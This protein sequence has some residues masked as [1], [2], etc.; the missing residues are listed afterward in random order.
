MTQALRAQP[1]APGL[2]G[3]RRSGAVTELLF[4]FECL[5]RE[6]AQ[7]RP[8]AD[9]LGLTVQAASHSFRQL[10]RRGLAEHRE[11]R[12]RTTVRGVA[13]LHEV[14]GD[15][16]EDI[17]ERAARLRVIRSCR[18]IAREPLPAHA[19][20]S[21]ELDDGLLYAR[22]GAGPG[23]RG[24]TQG[25][26]RRGE[27]V[28]VSDLEG[29]VPL[30]RAP[31]RILTLSSGDLEDPDLTL[32]LRRALRAHPAGLLGAQGLEAFHALRRA[33][34]VPVVR[35]AVAAQVDEASRLGVPSTVLL[36]PSELPRFLSQMS[37]PDPPPL[38]VFALGGGAG[39][40]HRTRARARRRAQLRDERSE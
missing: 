6:P 37:E 17:R 10:A 7:L 16:A 22:R 29:I 12:Y 8:I 32:R 36:L 21:L 9:R 14:L 2:G 26:A 15:L 18:A 38:S 1:R 30:D 24:R 4:L 5:T 3:L 19:T 31:V 40:P 33:T 39:G 20:V 11:G 23:S 28:T 35:F 34:S 13:W 27:L 25:A